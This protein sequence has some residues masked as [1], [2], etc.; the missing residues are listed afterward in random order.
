MAAMECLED[1]PIEDPKALLS[2]VQSQHQTLLHQSERIDELESQLA[3]FKRQIFGR[4]SERFVAPDQLDGDL[5]AKRSES[6]RLVG[7]C[8]GE[9]AHHR[10]SRLS[11]PAAVSFQRQISVVNPRFS[12]SLAETRR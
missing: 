3:W 9:A 7:L 10:G 11:I 8:A 1:Q 5:Q 2:L 12:L 4:K 6:F